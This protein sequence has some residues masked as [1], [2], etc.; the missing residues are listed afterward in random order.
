M[1]RLRY[2]PFL[3]TD[4]TPGMEASLLIIYFRSARQRTSSDT[5]TSACPAPMSRAESVRTFAFI[6]LSTV[7]ISMTSPE[8]SF[9][10]MA[11]EVT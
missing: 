4:E 9:D 8:R 7:A 1:R 10:A 6:E 2:F 5:F 3:V 11:S